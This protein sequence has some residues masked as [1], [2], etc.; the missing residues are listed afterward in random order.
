MKKIPLRGKYGDGK[1]ALVDDEDS[2]KA[3]CHKWY[4]TGGPRGGYVR[5]T[6]YLGGGHAHPHHKLL[7]LHQLVMNAPDGVLVD[8][9][10]G[11]KL[12]NRK[13]QLRLCTN[14]EN[15][16]NVPAP[17]HN[18]SGYKGVSFH[19]VTGKWSASIRLNKKSK[20][21]GI[22]LTPKEAARAYNK[23]A[24]EQWGEFAHL[25]SVAP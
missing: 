14:A 2:E 12:D 1:F 8:H 7:G 4:L 10:Y 19:K 17:R 13:S 11:D 15:C 9:I 5:T 18:T 25:N 22:Y 20:H 21:I 16:R 23:V 3:N 24:L 6:V